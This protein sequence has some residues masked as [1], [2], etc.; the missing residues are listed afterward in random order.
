MSRTSKTIQDLFDIQVED[1]KQTLDTLSIFDAADEYSSVIVELDNKLTSLHH[2]LQIRE[3]LQIDDSSYESKDNFAATTTDQSPVTFDVDKATTATLSRRYVFERKLRGG[4]VHLDNDEEYYVPEQM[5]RDMNIL[6]GAKVSII[7]EYEHNKTTRY[8]FHVEENGTNDRPGRVEVKG[9]RVHVKEF[10]KLYAVNESTR[11]TY[12]ISMSDISTY[13]INYMDTV[14]IAYYENNPTNI[15]V[16]HKHKL[17]PYAA[18]EKK[19]FLME[20]ALVATKEFSIPP[21]EYKK[22]LQD[23]GY[24]IGRVKLC[25]GTEMMYTLNNYAGTMDCLIVDPSL[26]KDMSET[27]QLFQNANKNVYYCR[28]LDKLTK[29]S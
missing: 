5:V 26:S 20:T 16:I 21:D 4:V 9:C 27:I 18:P 22:A 13:G 19:T 1:L 7:D 11:E 28:Y 6:H 10:N 24:L 23:S 3:S 15:S 8:I 17:P 2:L 25:Y 14:D 29:G 12:P